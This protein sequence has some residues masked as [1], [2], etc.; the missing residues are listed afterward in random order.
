MSAGVEWVVRHP[1]FGLLIPAALA[2][3]VISL[4]RRPVRPEKAANWP[5]TEATIQSVGKVVVDAGR[6]SYSVDVGDFSYKVKGEYYSGRLTISRSFST[7]DRSPRDL[8][9]QKIQVR[10][11]PP[12]PEKFF[13][14]QAEV[15]GFLLDPYDEPFGKDVG[16]I[17]LNIDKIGTGHG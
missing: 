12:K 4:V 5:V 8:I 6:S 2:T 14:P 16:A 13:V 17:D 9:N 7:G 10:Y 15:N 3:L 1:L 11:N